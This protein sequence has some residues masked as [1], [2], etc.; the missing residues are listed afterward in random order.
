VSWRFSQ[1]RQQKERLM[2][3]SDKASVTPRLSPREKQL[4]RGLARNKSD[5]KIAV[6]IVAGA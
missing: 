4:L 5:E 3:K 2:M 1:H 6:G